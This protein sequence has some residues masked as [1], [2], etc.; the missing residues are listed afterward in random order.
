MT[1]GIVA[2]LLIASDEPATRAI[3]TAVLAVIAIVAIKLALVAINPPGQGR[4]ASR[5]GTSADQR[6]EFDEVAAR[7][8]ALEELDSCDE[9]PIDSSTTTHFESQHVRKEVDRLQAE[10]DE[11]VARIGA[12]E[13]LGRGSEAAIA[14]A[15]ATQFELQHVR[16]ELDRLRSQVD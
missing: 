3:G 7:I 16:E 13:A 14:S 4:S 10:V 9:N 5:S 6:S 15:A 2:T 1:A 12:L 8:D 11:I